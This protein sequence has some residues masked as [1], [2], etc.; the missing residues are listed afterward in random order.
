MA[1]PDRKIWDDML[2]HLHR[3]HPAVCRN[4]FASLEPIGIADGS[5]MVRVPNDM[6]RDYLRRECLDA[7]NDAARTA[8][9][10]LVPVRF[11]GPDDLAPLS[12]RSVAGRHAS[13]PIAPAQ[14][15][16]RASSDD[17]DDTPRYDDTRP[18]STSRD[19]GRREP[20]RRHH[21][22]EAELA[23]GPETLTIN[24]DYDFDT[25]IVGPTNR[26]AHAAASAVSRDPGHAYNPFFVHGG[27][28]LGKTH[29]LQAICGAV[30]RDRPDTVIHYV[31]CD[32]FINDFMHSVQ[33]GK[34]SEFRHR[35]RDVDLLVIDDIHFLA[36]RDRTQE[37]FF[38]T[39]NSLYQDKRQIVLSS[40]APPEEIPDLEDRLVSRFNWGLVTKVEPPSYETRVAILHSKAAM[41]SLALPDAVA[42]FVAERIN[43]NIRELEGAVV[44]LHIMSTVEG[45]PV[46]LEMARDAIGAAEPAVK[47]DP[48][49][50]DI[51]TTVC[52]FYEVK[53]TELLGKRRHQSISLPRQ[54]CM[55]LA[56]EHTRHSLEEIGGHFG[57]RDHSTVLHAVRSIAGRCAN[58]RD[59]AATVDEL[60]GS[61]QAVASERGR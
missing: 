11:L 1:D 36:N 52:S 27:V 7:F 41:R 4:W 49:L 34:M 45:R 58:D 19:A 20:D 30:L 12:T 33:R 46:D 54:I 29:L 23:R 6:H 28:G 61:I 59:L 51:I 16:A 14:A 5:M 50:E 53:R 3:H 39:F 56:R 55:F 57:G 26:L 25:F 44:K 2:A 42:C 15:N 35:F 38:H 22:S 32:G 21:G 9:N 60:Q 10:S 37:E 40:D 17:N 48:T 31:S 43:S 24:P 47:R 18:S 13:A 8:T